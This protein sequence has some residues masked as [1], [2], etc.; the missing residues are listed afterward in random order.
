MRAIV[1]AGFEL[2]VYVTVCMIRIER[3]RVLF[4]KI[5]LVK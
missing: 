3:F 2:V 4:E 1:R 5:A